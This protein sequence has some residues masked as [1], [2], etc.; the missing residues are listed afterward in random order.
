[1]AE[2]NGA[3]PTTKNEAVLLAVQELGAKA[4]R[5]QIRDYIKEKFGIEMGLDHVSTARSY[6]LRKLGKPARRKAGRKPRAAK[7]EGA[8]ET[9][10]APKA[11]NETIVE[12]LIT[13]KTLVNKMG[14]EK[15]KSL[16]SLFN[17]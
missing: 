10:A 17:D 8:T 13:L 3:G 1:M 16:I 5:A 9:P 15:L 2:Q 14:A 7:V 12:D 4:K 11:R 6:A